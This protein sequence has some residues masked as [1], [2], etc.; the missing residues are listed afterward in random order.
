MALVSL[1]VLENTLNTPNKINNPFIFYCA[2][3]IA[4]IIYLFIEDVN[5]VGVIA[6]PNLTPIND[7]LIHRVYGQLQQQ[8][9]FIKYHHQSNFIIEFEVPV[10]NNDRGLKGITTDSKKNVWLYH[11][12]NTSSVII[13]F[14]PQN[15]TFTK[16]PI[17][18]ILPPV[19][20]KA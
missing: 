7:L 13:E 1:W 3:I 6:A 10:D 12:T 11:N 20:T 2:Y 15:K 5:I 4:S 9:E 17:S 18:M 19:Y 8:T 16:Y 14:N